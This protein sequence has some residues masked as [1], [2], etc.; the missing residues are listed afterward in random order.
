MYDLTYFSLL[1]TVKSESLS[2]RK[3]SNGDVGLLKKDR[4]KQ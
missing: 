4:H 3:D 2:S 1:F